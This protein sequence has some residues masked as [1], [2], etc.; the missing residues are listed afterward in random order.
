M[1]SI[2]THGPISVESQ[3]ASDVVARLGVWATGR[4]PVYRELADALEAAIATGALI[5]RLPSERALAGIVGVSRTTAVAA[6]D[7]L[8]ERGLIERR[9]GSG[10]YALRRRDGS[11]VCD[12]PLDCIRSS[13]AE[14]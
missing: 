12:D 2:V 5:G 8:V 13:F 9:R 10:T 14:S 1:A 6:Y 7:R 3:L 4:G 11:A